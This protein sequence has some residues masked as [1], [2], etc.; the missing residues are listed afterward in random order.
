MNV[1]LMTKTGIFQLL[2]LAIAFNSYATFSAIEL[3]GDTVTYEFEPVSLKAIGKKFKVHSNVT[4]YQD[5]ADMG[6]NTSV[7]NVGSDGLKWKSQGYFQRNRDLGQ[8]FI[9]KKDT[10][11]KSIVVRTG[12]AESAVLYDTPGS[13]VFIQFFEIFGD[14]IINDNG[15][16]AGT[17]SAH[18]FNTNHRTDD[19]IEGVE[20][21]SLPV[22]YTGVFPEDAPATKDK[23]GNFKGDAGCL[24][25]IRWS[26]TEPVFFKANHRYGFIIG[27]A[28][29][30]SELGFTLANANRAAAT[31]APDLDDQNTPYKGGWS[32]RREGDGTLPPT[33]IP[34][35]NPPESSRLVQ[36]LK[37]ESVFFPGND[38]FNLS[39]TSDGFP[40]VDTYRALE[41]YIEE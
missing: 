35:E 31:D 36:Q 41:F 15:T 25:Y 8:V 10:W 40:D 3:L 34:G 33:M 30:G 18:G 23:E 12:P 20:Y 39:P 19:F 2:F 29:T 6:G 14:P 9:P 4:E 37:S 5:K 7:R 38:R 13:K 24:V 21:K 16:P 28:E 22:I 11:V 32:F 26:F 1:M 27:F 17:K